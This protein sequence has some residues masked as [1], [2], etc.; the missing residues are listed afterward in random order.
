M[1]SLDEKTARIKIILT[2]GA[3]QG[4]RIQKCSEPLLLITAAEHIP[5]KPPER[6]GIFPERRLDPVAG[7]KSLNYLYNLLARD[8][9]LH[10]GLDEAVL[11]GPEGESLECA[12]S[13]IF[14]QRGTTVIKP[15]NNGYF[16]EGIMGRHFIKTKKEQGCSVTE[17]TLLPRDISDS[18]TV[19]I[20]NSIIGVCPV[21][22]VKDRTGI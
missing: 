2:R 1:N 22:I 13:N 15:L 21:K 10:N 19:F 3:E 8:W 20:T 17:K 5:K 12:A 9:A 7:H 6:I 11:T 18:D 16:L 4:L 14:I